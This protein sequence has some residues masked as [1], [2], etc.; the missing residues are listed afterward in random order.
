MRGHIPFLFLLKI[1]SVLAIGQ[2]VSEV[3]VNQRIKKA[4][5]EVA[6]ARQAVNSAETDARQQFT[7]L[8]QAKLSWNN[9]LDNLKFL[10]ER[11]ES[12]NNSLAAS[13]THQD[14]ELNRYRRKLQRL[15]KENGSAEEIDETKRYIKAYENWKSTRLRKN[16]LNEWKRAIESQIS[17]KQN[18]QTALRQTL[19]NAINRTGLAEDLLNEKKKR[20]QEAEENLANILLEAPELLAYVNPPY[21]KKVM[22]AR[23]GNIIYS[24]EWDDYVK[25]IDEQI[26]IIQK[27][28]IEQKSVIEDQKKLIAA[29]IDELM[30]Q[31]TLAQEKLDIYVAEVQGWGVTNMILADLLDAGLN[32]ARNFK[33]MGPYAFAF[34]AAYR[35]GELGLWYSGATG[36]VNEGWDINKLPSQPNPPVDF[37]STLAGYG[38]SNLK[39]QIKGQVLNIL[40]SYIGTSEFGIPGKELDFSA[41]PE[42]GSP[43]N[44]SSLKGLKEKWTGF[45]QLVSEGKFWVLADESLNSKWLAPVTDPNAP[46]GIRGM[47]NTLKRNPKLFIQNL[48]SSFNKNM[49][50]GALLDVVQTSFIQKLKNRAN[51]TRLN[52]WSDY[53]IEDI[54]RQELTK[55]LKAAGEKREFQTQTLTALNEVLLELIR[56]REKQAEKG[57]RFFKPIKNDV[58]S[59]NGNFKIFLEF[60]APVTTDSV[61]LGGKRIE[62]RSEDNIWSGNFDLVGIKEDSMA[63]LIVS[64][65]GMTSKKRLDDPRTAAQFQSTTQIWTGY[66]E[67][68]DRYHRIKLRPL[69]SGTSILFLVDCSGSMQDNGRMQKAISAARSVLSSAQFEP[70]DEI[71]LMAFY[72]CGSVKLLQP[73]THNTEEFNAKLSLLTPS[74]ATPLCAA[75]IAGSHYLE[76]TGRTAYRKMIIL[77]DGEETCRGNEFETLQRIKKFHHDIKREIL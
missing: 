6:S 25:L 2:P 31:N 61:T 10:Q 53:L 65:S 34:E 9:I 70:T 62:G 41:F 49:L 29:A 46:G 64:A 7:Q 58:L 36:P 72:D 55:I 39:D 15:Q 71:A 38:M 17:Q 69:R 45:R 21:L 60:T 50:K 48:K 54:R 74:G 11:L 37:T 13:V 5:S 32:I 14:N 19:Q 3:E 68:E 23:K 51:E 27:G 16:G 22:V 12:A 56:E 52:K 43:G 67:I 76:S 30:D 1:S 73:F 57:T 20:L 47:F 66:E 59:G 26:S 35:V 75:M 33:E 63:Q 44:F 4:K 8:K 28:I 77:T 18:E 42:R 40:K 24:A